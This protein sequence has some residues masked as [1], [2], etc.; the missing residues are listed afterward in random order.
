MMDQIGRTFLFDYGGI[1]IKVRYLSDRDLEWEQVR[2]PDA[3]LK[4]RETYHAV[5]VRPG[6]CFIW[7]QEK[8]TSV[9]AQ[10]VDFQERKVYTAWISPEKKVEQFQGTI[11]PE[12]G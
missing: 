4:G 1:A 6:A 5:E 9:V 12:G 3:G 8:D 11:R 10:V 2:G 7:W